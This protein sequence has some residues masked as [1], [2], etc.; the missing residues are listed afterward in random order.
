MT[1]LEGVYCGSC[2]YSR[3][4]AYVVKCGCLD[5]LQQNRR[6]VRLRT[7]I[8]FPHRSHC[9]RHYIHEVWHRH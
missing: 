5:I 2:L 4:D 1:K 9:D 3:T 8:R 7:S 6:S